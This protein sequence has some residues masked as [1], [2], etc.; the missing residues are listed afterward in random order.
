MKHLTKNQLSSITSY[1]RKHYKTGPKIYSDQLTNIRNLINISSYKGLRHFKHKG[2]E[3]I[4]FHVV[5]PK[6]KNLNFEDNV[7]FLDVEN[8]STITT[9]TRQIKNQY[10]K[11][12]K[13]F[14]SFYENNCAKNKI[15]YVQIDT[16]QP[17]DVSI[18]QYLVKRSKL[19]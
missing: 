17:L 15:D 12:F 7:K 14:C 4:I 3:V 5:D 9:D 18:M 10:N 19:K 6:E 1:I 13:D 8:N 2:H 16:N 11:A